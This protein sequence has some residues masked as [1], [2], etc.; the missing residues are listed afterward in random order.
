MRSK[1]RVLTA[2]VVLVG[3]LGGG[4][5]AASA[6]SSPAVGTGP[7]NHVK[8]FS[9]VLNGTVKPN[10]APTSYQFEWGLT[11]DYG[12]TSAVHS[13]G[14]GTT[15]VAVQTVANKLLPGTTYHY[16]LTARSKFGGTLGRDRTFKTA[17]HA[18]AFAG[19]GPATNPSSSS[20]TLTG[21]VN[22][23][24]VDTSYYFNYGLTTAYGS[25]TATQVVSGKSGA[26]IV[27]VEV[28]GLASGTMF[29]YQLVAVNRGVPSVGADGVFM[30]FPNPAPAPQVHKFSNPRRDRHGPFTYTISGHI[31]PPSSIPAQ[32]ACAGNAT[33]N[34]FL[35]TH[36]VANTLAAV[37]PDCK[38]SG[39]ITLN[40]KPGHGKRNRKVDL[41]VLVHYNGDGYLAPARSSVGHITAG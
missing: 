4:A 33:I 28:Q 17:G 15:R 12:A 9:A 26:Q 8:E 10:G 29:H 6:A 25:R 32:F 31:T 3:L 37:G 13:A 22:P 1:T 30:T 14:H 36:R 7:A 38:F 39:Q 23:N 35:H 40:R 20:I 19:T 18:P 2:A 11:T 34:L 27:A 41:R 24:H 21:V 16:R 5:I